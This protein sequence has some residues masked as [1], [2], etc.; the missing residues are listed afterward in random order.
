[1]IKSHD[2]MNSVTKE[3]DFKTEPESLKNAIKVEAIS[4]TNLVQLDVE[5]QGK[6]ASYKLCK[7][8]A[9]SFLVATDELYQKRIDLIN[10]QIE[11][12]N[13]Q[14]KLVQ[15]DIQHTRK[16]VQNL[17]MP[18]KIDETETGNGIILLQNTLPDWHN[19]FITLFNQKNNLQLIL[20]NAKE[21]KLVDLT[22]PYPIWPN[23]KLNI[24][25]AGIFSLM[26]GIF[27]AFFVEFWQKP[28]K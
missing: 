16:L 3:L 9:N 13:S 15:S 24:A 5:Y 10:Q 6:V 14:M 4:D 2:F 20:V 23:K 12:L 22:K 27:L 1:M 11:G 17:S 25:I 18:E 8:I 19:N 7:Q 28:G 21:F 26:F